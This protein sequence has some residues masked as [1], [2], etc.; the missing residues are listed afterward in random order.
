MKFCDYFGSY[1]SSEKV[2]VR[3]ADHWGTLRSL[4]PE[5]KGASWEVRGCGELCWEKERS[6]RG[7]CCSSDDDPRVGYCRWQPGAHRGSW[8]LSSRTHKGTGISC[9]LR[10]EHTYAKQYIVLASVIILNQLNPPLITALPKNVTT[11]N[12]RHILYSSRSTDTRLTKD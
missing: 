8:G 1:L 11:T 12:S 7:Y 5:L 6:G 10:G 3:H 9:T 2:Q 4:P